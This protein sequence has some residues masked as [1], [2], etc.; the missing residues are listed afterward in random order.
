[1]S[2]HETAIAEAYT[3]S[4]ECCNVSKSSGLHLK[5]VEYLLNKRV[6]L[7]WINEIGGI[8]HIR[9][10]VKCKDDLRFSSILKEERLD[11]S[12]TNKDGKTILHYG[13]LHSSLDENI[14]QYISS[15]GMLN[16]EH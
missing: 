5:L 9:L 13:A 16:V 2:E 15:L 8:W 7:S 4:K 11:L 12:T 1:M 14:F 3:R 6:A 10:S